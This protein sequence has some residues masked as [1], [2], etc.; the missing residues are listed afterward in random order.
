MDCRAKEGTR[1]G[2]IR[3]NR[4]LM[5]DNM[6][7]CDKLRDLATFTREGARLH[8]MS[9][10]MT[11]EMLATALQWRFDANNWEA[12]VICT[13]DAKAVAALAIELVATVPR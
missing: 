7:T 8:I 4:E 10:Q 1:R 2:F 11:P 13:Q 5:E 6:T 9:P 3:S 12:P